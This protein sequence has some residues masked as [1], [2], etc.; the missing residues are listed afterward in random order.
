MKRMKVGAMITVI[1]ALFVLVGCENSAQFTVRCP[2][3]CDAIYAGQDVATDY[4]RPGNSRTYDITWRGG[5]FGSATETVTFRAK[6][7]IL[8]NRYYA[9]RTVVLSDGDHFTWSV[10]WYYVRCESPDS[11]MTKEVLD[12]IKP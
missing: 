2:S 5:L 10:G 12:E 4:I 7:S 8:P 11:L 6:D 9:S 3:N 1:L